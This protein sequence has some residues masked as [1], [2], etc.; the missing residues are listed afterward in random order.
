PAGAVPLLLVDD[1]ALTQN[2]AILNY[3]ADIAPLT[4]LSGDGTA[5]SRAEINRWIAFVN[6][7][8]HPTF[9]PI[10]GSTAYLQDP[11]LIARSQDDARVD[12]HLQG[13]TWLASDSHTGA[14]AYLFVTLLWAQK[15]AVN[16]DG[17]NALQAFVQRMLADA[18]VQAAL[19]AEGLA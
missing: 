9:K 16:L 19:K 7:D 15:A 5:R 8:V 18:D 13:R 17:L 11:A 10:F 12:A 4:G 2:A 14:D 3:I 1:W 6:A